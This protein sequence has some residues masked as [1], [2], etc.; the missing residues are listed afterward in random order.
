MGN[1]INSA[2]IEERP[3][4]FTV[5]KDYIQT[6]RGV[7]NLVIRPVVHGL[8]ITQLALAALCATLNGPRELFRLAD[9]MLYWVT[10]PNRIKNFDRSVKKLVDS[11]VKGSLVKIASKVSKLYIS[12]LMMVGLIADAIKHLHVRE[13]IQLSAKSLAVLG[14]ISLM[15]SFSLLILS[16]HEM[17]KQ[18]KILI[19]SEPWSPQF[20]LALINLIN[21]VCLAALA[22]VAIITAL[23]AAVVSP[24]IALGFGVGLLVTSVTAHFYEKIH[25]SPA[26]KTVAL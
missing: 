17:K 6:P 10:Y 4:P 9:H 25:V 20:N 23:T 1:K 13:V 7:Q 19:N 24:W 2:R 12:T 3:S 16:G 8:K 15:G 22:I 14:Q 5:A 18:V 21:R 26:S 11:I